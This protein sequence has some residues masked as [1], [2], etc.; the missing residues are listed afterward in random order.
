MPVF[1]EPRL[2]Y[3]TELSGQGQLPHIELDS[4]TKRFGDVLA[5]DSISCEIVAGGIHA[6]LGENGA[7]KS[8][9]MKILCGYYQ[10][11]AGSIRL[12]REHVE[13]RF[14]SSARSM[15]IGMV[16]QHFTLV[17]SMT[18]LENVLLGDKRHGFLVNPKTMGALIEA[19]ACQFGIKLDV[20][21]TIS[22][23]SIS[24]RQKV[25]IL[26]LLWRDARILILD[27]PTSQLAPFE[28][29]EILS[30]MDK[31]AKQGK[32]VT[33]I[34]HHIDEIVRF[35]SR[36]TVLRK[37]KC[38]AT[39][40]KKDVSAQELAKLMVDTT[41]V[42]M[43]RREKQAVQFPLLVMKDVSLPQGFDHRSLNSIS[44]NI[45]SAEVLGIAGVSGSGQDELAR[46]L[47]G[48]MKPES[49]TLVFNGKVASWHSLKSAKGSAGFV[50]AD[51]NLSTVSTLSVKDNSLLRDIHNSSF[52]WGP[53]LRRR[54]VRETAIARINA[55][56]VRPSRSDVL[57]GKLSGGNQQ[58]LVV[59][60]ELNNPAPLLVAVNPT[61]GLDLA[62]STRVLMELKNAAS[63]GKAVV[64]ISQDLEELLSTC[65]RIVVM[66]AGTIVGD[67]QVEEL[68]PESLGLLIGGVGIDIVRKLTKFLHVESSQLH[69]EETMKALCALM[70]SD[71][72]WQRRLAA[73]IAL[74]V[75]VPDN[76][77]IIEEQLL[78]ESNDE[79]R[80]WLHVILVKLKYSEESI[81]SLTLAFRQIPAAFVE[82]E[83]R[84]LK[85]E[86]L[87][88]LR[89]ILAKR[90]NSHSP[91]ENI[92]VH[93]VLDHLD[94]KSLSYV[95]GEGLMGHYLN[96][97]SQISEPGVSI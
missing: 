10:P 67:E 63:L 2:S 56:D 5:N 97:S 70:S 95:P 80:A 23:L 30:M 62:M 72:S 92:L 43:S 53:F 50:P 89:T 39:F 73:Q 86:D 82:V 77:H 3:D 81:E 29:E 58:R 66:H 84:L 45:Y 76:C 28:A 52:T 22:R 12:D 85:C 68:D 11:D 59:A 18:V 13:F 69:D 96:T 55:F 19:K 9:L 78:R 46:I 24:E 91:W 17:P 6:F 64:L 88:S 61:A 74:K 27:E 83:R 25:E 57:C 8:T 31:L 71:S 20:F 44:L 54:Q 65:D 40:D 7:G 94:A 60:R 49:G 35:A 34:S 14:P 32:I 4:I 75:F 48:H 26:K 38:I 37:G 41:S 36:V 90:Q 47:T 16:H 42:L 79:C 93:L 87:A 1:L 51:I 21:K 15:G 33:F